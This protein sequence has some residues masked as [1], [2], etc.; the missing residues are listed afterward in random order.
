MWLNMAIS[1]MHAA[2]F[3]QHLGGRFHSCTYVEHWIVS[4]F[5]ING[6]SKHS[7]LQLQ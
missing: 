5:C 7:S 2:S 1:T 3:S 6:H 4:A